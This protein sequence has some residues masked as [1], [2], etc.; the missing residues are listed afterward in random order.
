VKAVVF[1]FFGTLTVP[2]PAEHHRIHLNP[3]AEALGCDPQAFHE[4][5]SAS[6]YERATG[7]WGSPREALHRALAH[8]DLD[9]S[10][11]RVDTAL[12]VRTSKFGEYV[13]LRPDAVAT[14]T[15]LRER[16]L[17]VA[18]LSDCTDDLPHLWPSLP[19]APL[20]DVTVFSY[21]YGAHKPDPV[22]YEAAAR[23]LAV[24]AS[25]CLYVG[26]GGSDELAG[27]ERAGM[28]AV[29]IAAD[30]HFGYGH[31]PWDGP[32]VHSLSELLELDGVRA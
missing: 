1:D 25:D 16:G 27:A 20:V 28:T 11:E 30:G 13:E 29:R 2:I 21:E 15:Q 9:L 22:L 26:D 5:W 19:I 31:V 6:F 12:A 3:V 14:L 23:E 7:A 4:A 18:V 24:L 17:G 10:P 32:V 8:L